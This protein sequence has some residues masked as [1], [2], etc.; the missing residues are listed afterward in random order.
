MEQG[1]E[2]LPEEGASDAAAAMPVEAQALAEEGP[3]P[4]EAGADGEAREGREGRRGRGRDRFRREQEGAAPGVSEDEGLP[5]PAINGAAEVATATALPEDAVITAPEPVLEEVT[6]VR[7]PVAAPAPVAAAV[8]VPRIQVYELPLDDLRLV[9]STAGLEWVN[10][11]ADKV[12]QVQEAI[13]SMPAPIH[14]R[15]ERKPVVTQDDGP[16]VLVETRKDLTQFNLP[17][18]PPRTDVAPPAPQH[19]H[20]MHPQQQV[21]QEAQQQQ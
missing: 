19:Q 7:V 2:G 10:S 13:A 17:F 20:L 9:A 4:A 3:L 6:A 8:F 12:R 1:A 14:T 5:L 18:T 21:Q 11:D 15:R 16:L